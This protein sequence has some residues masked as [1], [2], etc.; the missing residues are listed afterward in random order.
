M[1]RTSY[2]KNFWQNLFTFN[3]VFGFILILIWG[4]LRFIIVLN[5]NETAN[6]QWVSLVFISMWIAPFIFLNKAGRKKIGINK[7][8]KFVWLLFSFVLGI[9]CCSLMFLIASTLYGDTINN[10]FVYISR[11]YPIAS[12]GFPL[13][14]KWSIFWVYV[15]IGMTFSPIGEE[16]FYRGLVHESFA[17]QWGDRKAS[18]MDS[19]AFSL[20]H[21]AHFGIVYLSGT[22]EVLVWPGLLWIGL[23]F[24]TCIVFFICRKKTGSMLGAILCHA[25]YNFAMT[26]LIF[27]YVL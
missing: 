27:F 25:G 10:W 26:Y 17:L 20:T 9:L 21:L 12:V 6:Y 11:S 24:G 5:A 8:G 16:L 15:L 7:P 18:L 13:D 14:E 3:A 22:W 23:L 19:A 4:I 2:L 1:M